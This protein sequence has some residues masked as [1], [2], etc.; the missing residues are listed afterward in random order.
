MI[1]AGRCTSKPCRGTVFVG[2]LDRSFYSPEQRTRAV[3][4][5]ADYGRD[6]LELIPL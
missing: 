6:A 1:P 3:R 4:R 2:Y 5:L